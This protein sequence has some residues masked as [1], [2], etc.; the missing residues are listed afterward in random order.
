MVDYLINFSLDFSYYIICLLVGTTTNRFFGSD[1]YNAEKKNT[2]PGPGQYNLKNDS[3]TV[4]NKNSRQVRSVFLSKTNRFTNDEEDNDNYDINNEEMSNN[5]NSNNNSTTTRNN[6]EG[7]EEGPN[8][9]L[10][11]FASSAP[12][13]APNSVF[14]N[15]LQTNTPGPGSYDIVKHNA[16]SSISVVHANPVSFQT[17]DRRFKQ[18]AYSFTKGGNK[19]NVFCIL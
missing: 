6:Q 9:A 19:N 12:R 1:V 10:Y 17:N 13:F 7:G 16:T 5:I 2:L 11:P 15:I 3:G 8:T 18:D 14:A 4:N